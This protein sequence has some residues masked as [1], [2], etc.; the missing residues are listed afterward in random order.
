MKITYLSVAENYDYRYVDSYNV[1]QIQ[2]ESENP[3]LSTTGL[4]LAEDFLL[5]VRIFLALSKTIPQI[6]VL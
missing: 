5:M 2:A 3:L 1:I 6:A 4:R